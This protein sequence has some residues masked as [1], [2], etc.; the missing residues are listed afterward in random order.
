MVFGFLSFGAE[1]ESN[2][3]TE[4]L[5]RSW[6]RV[7]A[8]VGYMEDAFA[9][10]FSNLGTAYQNQAAVTTT[11]TLKIIWDMASYRVWQVGRYRTTSMVGHYNVNTGY[12]AFKPQ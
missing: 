5:S 1:H 10:Y 4:E 6:N 8:G 7:Y 2:G 9:V 3:R 12:G 11:Q